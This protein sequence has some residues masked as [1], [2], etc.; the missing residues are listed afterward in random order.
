MCIRQGRQRLHKNKSAANVCWAALRS[1][2]LS[3]LAE[4]H[5]GVAG[6][7][8]ALGATASPAH[9]AI[10]LLHCRFFALL[11]DEVRVLDPALRGLQFVWSY[12]RCKQS[13]VHVLLL[14]YICR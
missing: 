14:G 11:T 4:K 9:A 3:K 8:V 13:D 10:R 5:T 7:K 6:E 2:K 1:D 12:R